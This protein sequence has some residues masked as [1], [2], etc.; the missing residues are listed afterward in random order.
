MAPQVT[1][2][3]EI[4]ISTEA[5]P[6][7]QEFAG[8]VGETRIT[9]GKHKGKQFKDALKDTQY[10]TW[11]LHHREQLVKDSLKCL[12]SFFVGNA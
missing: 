6:E 8:D 4:K 5:K 2:V 9:S 3:F 1:V 10:V 12:A 7:P 11:V